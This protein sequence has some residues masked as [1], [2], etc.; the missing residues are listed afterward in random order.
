MCMRF[1]LAISH[2]HLVNGLVANRPLLESLASDD[3]I[4]NSLIHVGY[5][6]LFNATTFLGISFNIGIFRHCRSHYT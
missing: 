1:H 4:H 5:L 3:T 2:Q 6:I